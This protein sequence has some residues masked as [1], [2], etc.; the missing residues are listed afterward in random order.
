MDKGAEILAAALSQRW[1]D[2]RLQFTSCRREFSEE[3]VHDLRVAARRFLAVLDIVRALEPRSPI[4]KTRRF[5]KDQLDEFDELRDVQVMRIELLEALPGVPELVVFEPLLQ[6][7]EKRLMRAAHRWA[8]E[9]HLSGLQKR[10]EK[11]RTALQRTGGATS[12]ASLLHAVDNAYVRV[13]QA[14]DEIDVKKPATIH[15]ARIAF[16]KFRYMAEIAAPLLPAPPADYFKCMHDYQSAMGDIR[17]ITV[18]LDALDEAAREGALTL[19]VKPMRRYFSRRLSTRIS[20]FIRK[21]RE[22][23]TFWRATPAGPFPWEGTPE[24]APHG[25]RRRGSGGAHR[26][27]GRH[28]ALP[29]RQELPEDAPDRPRPAER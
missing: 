15:Q 10:V 28:P 9:S 12:A 20:R 1:E 18:F 7:R 25:S 19:D 11:I 16:K 5:F 17:D 22:L 14:C 23:Q 26:G 29:E 2:Y 8:V 13:W 3:A 21:M 24:A 4:Q 27:G 6:K